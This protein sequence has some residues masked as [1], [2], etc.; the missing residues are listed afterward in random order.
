[1][2]LQLGKVL[3]Y[4]SHSSIMTPPD[5]LTYTKLGGEQPSIRVSGRVMSLMCD[6]GRDSE[7]A[8]EDFYI[9]A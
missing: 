1:M 9:A 8:V 5:R 4:K 7:I 2:E 6:Y 3:L